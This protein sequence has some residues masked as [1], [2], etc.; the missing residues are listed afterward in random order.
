MSSANPNQFNREEKTGPGGVASFTFL[1]FF[2]PYQIAS[3]K[4]LV[5]LPFCLLYLLQPNATLCGYLE[6]YEEDLD[7]N[8][9]HEK[10]SMEESFYFC[11]PSV[12]GYS[13]LENITFDVDVLSH[14]VSNPG[15]FGVNIITDQPR[16]NIYYCQVKKEW[17]FLLYLDDADIL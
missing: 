14:C 6:H 5:L 3:G 11:F 8:D 4:I 15:P 9:L 1:T 10:H 12:L 13:F 16:D 7:P 17:C 2:F